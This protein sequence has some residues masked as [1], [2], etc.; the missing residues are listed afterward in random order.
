MPLE[1]KRV[2]VPNL[3]F[4]D[5]LKMFMNATALCMYLEVDKEDDDT[6]MNT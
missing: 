1:S 6:Q 5:G 3:S 2:P 4:A